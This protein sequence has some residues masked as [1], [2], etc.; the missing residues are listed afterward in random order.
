MEILSEHNVGQSSAAICE[1]RKYILDSSNDKS[2][3]PL[4]WW[5]KHKEM[6]PKLAKLAK[7]IL[8]TLATSAPS[9][10]AFSSAG[11]T[12][13]A[14]RNRLKPRNVNIILFIHDNF[15]LLN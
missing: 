3:D 14:K 12:V 10:R 15:E 6:F 4:P 8:C 9:E 11:L 1:I 2:L 7:S 13:T 5:K